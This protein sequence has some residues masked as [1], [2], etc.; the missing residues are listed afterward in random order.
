[1]PAPARTEDLV[2][3][4]LEHL[5]RVPDGIVSF[6][7]GCEGEPLVAADRIERAII[8]IRARTQD[9]TLQLN[10]NASL[11]AVVGKLFTA[12]LDSIRVSMNSAVPAHYAAYYKPVGYTFDDVRT[13]IGVARGKGGFVSINLLVHP[14]LSDRPSEIDAL[15]SLLNE[16]RVDLLQLRNLAID[17]DDYLALYP[18]AEAPVGMGEFLRRVRSGAPSVRLGSFNLPRQEWATYSPPAASRVGD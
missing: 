6:G 16:Y 12:G 1:M 7:Q 15:V 18:E 8:A 9:G 13:S 17:P 4:A 2:E 5:R 10:T 14:G 3:V 11:P